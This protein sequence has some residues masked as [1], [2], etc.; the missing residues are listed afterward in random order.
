MV[1]IMVFALMIVTVHCERS[2]YD[3]RVRRLWDAN[4]I[5][6]LI[7]STRVVREFDKRLQT[8]YQNRDVDESK[9][10]Y[11]LKNTTIEYMWIF[12]TTCYEY[13][14]GI[15]LEYTDVAAKLIITSELDVI[16]RETIELIRFVKDDI[17]CVP[18]FLFDVGHRKLDTILQTIHLF[19]SLTFSSQSSLVTASELKAKLQKFVRDHSLK[20]IKEKTV[21]KELSVVDRMGLEMNCQKIKK[22][23]IK[24]SKIFCLKN[25]PFIDTHFHERNI[26]YSPTHTFLS[27]NNN[28]YDTEKCTVYVSITNVFLVI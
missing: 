7:R 24:I 13:F 1:V 8:N 14:V 26:K 6:D 11:F 19:R 12:A 5:H 18:T 4:D 21:P 23:L 9:L 28:I 10:L 20:P 25:P 3:V 2:V 15:L 22:K 17:Y 27:F 16:D